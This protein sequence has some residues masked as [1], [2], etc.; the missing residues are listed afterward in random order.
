MEQTNASSL[1]GFILLGF[2]SR[3]ELRCLLFP[4]FLTMY[5]LTLLGNSL[6]VLLAR[7]DPRLRCAPMYI[8]LGHLSIVDVALS[9]T[10]V[11]RALLDLL[12]GNG[13]VSYM[14]CL[15]QTY[16]FLAF[17]STDSFLLACMAFDRYVAVCHPLSYA[18]IMGPW[19]CLGLVAGSWAISHLHSLLHVGLLARLSF[20]A[21][22]E[23]P[24]YF[25]DVQPLLRLACSS[26]HV[27]ELV[28]F[29][30]GSLLIMGPFIF[31]LGSYIFIF[32]AVLQLPSA[33]GRRK[34]MSTCGSHLA[35]VA[36]FYGTIIAVYI[37]P[38]SSYSAEHGRVVTVLYTAL[39]PM[40]NPLIYSLR[41]QEVAGAL[42]RA[43][44]KL[45]AP[46]K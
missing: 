45:H 12:W 15:A 8:L 3:P 16:F 43:L 11:P 34:A 9:S 36:L 38:A 42:R 6:M 20:C 44:D 18:A 1:P 24:H 31:I 13:A 32:T 27:N 14:G 40:L 35:A 39:T 28:I 41:N 21:S 7:T 26:T 17:G 23:I 33:Q 4:L 5:T 25:C 30:E 22:R 29:T 37:R 10:T 19:C 2:S 46:G